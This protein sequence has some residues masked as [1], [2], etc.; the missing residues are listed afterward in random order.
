MPRNVSHVSEG[1]CGGYH[2]TQVKIGAVCKVF[3]GPSDSDMQAVQMRAEN[4]LGLTKWLARSRASQVL[5]VFDM[6]GKLLGGPVSLTDFFGQTVT[7]RFSD[8]FCERPIPQ[9]STTFQ[10]KPINSLAL[11]CRFMATGAPMPHL[12][13]NVV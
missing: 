2:E 9:R 6:S 4:M 8:A 7:G 5:K 1:R 10:C 13:S 12:P 3:P 11:D